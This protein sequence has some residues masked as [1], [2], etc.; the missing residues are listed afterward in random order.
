MFEAAGARGIL[1]SNA[2][3][4]VTLYLN[5]TGNTVTEDWLTDG[6]MPDNL[7]GTVTSAFDLDGL[8]LPNARCIEFVLYLA[9]LK[10]REFRRLKDIGEAA[11]PHADGLCLAEHSR[12]VFSNPRS[13]LLGVC[14]TH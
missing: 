10:R 9:R 6:S 1:D 12:H 2:G 13:V 5:F 8:D 4:A 11:V 14:L 3:A 7:K